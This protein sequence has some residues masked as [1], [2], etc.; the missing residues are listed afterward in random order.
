MV[1]ADELIEDLWGGEPPRTAA[2]TL[3]TYVSHLRRALGA[4]AGRLVSQPPGYRL[5]VDDDA[6]D[7]CCFEALAA[8][9]RRLVPT[10]PGLDPGR[11]PPPGG[12][13]SLRRPRPRR[14]ARRSARAEVAPGDQSSLRADAARP[15]WR[16]RSPPGSTSASP[17]ALAS[18]T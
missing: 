6:V 16:W 10:D 7:A 17:T 11:Q 8:R 12:A 15:A 14:R 18:S 9:G 2:N 1:G 4:D 3:R 5:D 13:D